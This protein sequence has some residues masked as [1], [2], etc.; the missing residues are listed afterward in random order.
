M[1]GDAM[2]FTAGFLT[3]SSA[4]SLFF[5][6]F[7]LGWSPAWLF[8]SVITGILGLIIMITEFFDNWR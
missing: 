8:L 2:K 4:T 5:G 6:V 7:A 1:G 3:G